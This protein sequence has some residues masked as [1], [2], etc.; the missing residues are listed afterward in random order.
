SPE[1]FA[2]TAT[3]GIENPELPERPA[4]MDNYDEDGAMAA[5]E[6]FLRLSLYGFATGDWEY[7]DALS[8]SDCGFCQSYRDNCEK[9]RT[10]SVKRNMPEMKIKDAVAWHYEENAEQI[11]VNVV[12]E[13]YPHISRK[14]DGTITNHEGETTALAFLLEFTDDWHIVDVIPLMLMNTT[15]M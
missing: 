7:Y 2:I 9:G 1:S 14:S 13:R 10:S 15:K 3:E 11:R 6:Y 5:A 8:A 4:E 12:A